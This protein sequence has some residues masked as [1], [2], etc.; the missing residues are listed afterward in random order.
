MRLSLKNV[1]RQNVSRILGS[2]MVKWSVIIIDKWWPLCLQSPIR[3]LKWYDM[4]FE[5]F[6]FSLVNL[7]VLCF[8]YSKY[9]MNKREVSVKAEDLCHCVVI[10]QWKSNVLYVADISVVFPPVF[11][12]VS[13][14]VY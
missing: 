8:V 12:T 6:F 5:D 4:F 3:F 14:K 11:Y 1:N 7:S 9:I 10:H 2:L 13:T